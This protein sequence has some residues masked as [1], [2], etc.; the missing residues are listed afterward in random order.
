[1]KQS[2]TFYFLFGPF[3]TFVL[4]KTQGI[5]DYFGLICWQIGLFHDCSDFKNIWSLFKA[6]EPLI[7]SGE[8]IFDSRQNTFSF[9][10]API[11]LEFLKN[12]E[13]NSQ[14]TICESKITTKKDEKLSWDELDHLVIMGTISKTMN[15]P[16][17]VSQEKI[18]RGMD[19][20]LYLSPFQG[21]LNISLIPST[22]INSETEKKPLVLPV[23]KLHRFTLKRVETA[24]DHLPVMSKKCWKHRVSLKELNKNL[25][26]K[27]K[28]SPEKPANKPKSNKPTQAFIFEEISEKIQSLEE[29]LRSV[30][31]DVR[32]KRIIEVLCGLVQ[33]NLHKNLSFVPE[34]VSNYKSYSVLFK[35]E[36]DV[37]AK[38]IFN[39]CGMNPCKVLLSA[40]LLNRIRKDLYIDWF[41]ANE[42]SEDKKISEEM[43]ILKEYHHEN[44]EEREFVLVPFGSKS[45][46][47][48][49]CEG[50]PNQTK[51]NEG[52]MDGIRLN[53]SKSEME[54][55]SDGNE[56]WNEG[57]RGNN[58]GLS[59]MLDGNEE[60]QEEHESV[61]VLRDSRKDGSEADG[62]QK[63]TKASIQKE[64]EICFNE[65][66]EEEMEL[67]KRDSE[68]E[69]RSK[70]RRNKIRTREAEERK[71]I[72]TKIKE[73]KKILS[74]KELLRKRQFQIAI[75][76]EKDKRPQKENNESRIVLD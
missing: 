37:I 40:H 63:K 30:Q 36:S 51:I 47:E 56:S 52:K 71:T 72:E 18:L 64:G 43:K 41:L 11:P 69:K 31:V 39:R 50:A 57:E 55:E 46:K 20:H 26:K 16:N 12:M 60:S 10:S 8:V 66:E 42:D 53:E 33:R 15:Q 76:K 13:F 70:E 9:I 19:S 59:G 24:T 67:R 7:K 38:G 17:L 22:S 45:G 3:Q 27:S 65:M 14:P 74:Q 25:Q 49:K 75:E 4:W 48:E 54:A 34:A 68:F 73:D 29:K 5:K 21:A 2:M 32:K 44:Q 62:I 1:M 6:M 28:K 23:K 61:V 58:E 35:V